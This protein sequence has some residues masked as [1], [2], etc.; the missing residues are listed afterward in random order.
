MKQRTISAVIALLIF[1]PI[2]ILGGALFSIAMYVVS[3][4]ALREF[5]KIKQTKKDLPNFI[6]FISYMVMTLFVLSNVTNTD[7]LFT[8]DYRIIAGLFLVFTI[9]TVLYH[10]KKLYSIVDA[11]YLIGGVFF[12]GISFSLLI[13]LR[14]RGLDILLYLFLITAIT[15]TYAYLVG[16][17]I[18]RHKLL[19]DISPK[20]TWEGT[21]G[22]TLFGVVI[23]TVFYNTVVDQNLAIYVVIL[24]TLFLS[25]LGQFG[26]LFF[27]SIKRYYEKKD[28]SNIMPGHGGVLDRL[29]SIIFVILGFMF[30][31][32]II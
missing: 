1:V 29:D 5:L 25:L 27:S 6:T 18:G 19:E 2:F 17:L 24:M 14:N 10:N 20:K 12:L 21:I 31:I 23:G 26:D 8:I 22:G 9:P 4:I 13:L 30:F 32:T 3:I 16:M 7:I 11:F 28:F 15:D